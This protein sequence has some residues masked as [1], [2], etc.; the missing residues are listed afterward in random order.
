MIDIENYSSV[1]NSNYFRKTNRWIKAI[2]I[3]NKEKKSIIAERCWFNCGSQVWIYIVKYN[4][5]CRTF[6]T[7]K[8]YTFCNKF[9]LKRNSRCIEKLCLPRFICYTFLINDNI[10]DIPD[11]NLINYLFKNYESSI[12]NITY[13][14]DYN[15]NYC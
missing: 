14:H 2:K 1:E 13:F 7:E 9:N 10:F 8:I 11:V 15:L 4:T 3:A 12:K 5:G 6:L